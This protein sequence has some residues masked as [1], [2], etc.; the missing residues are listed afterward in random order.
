MDTKTAGPVG[1]T[2]TAKPDRNP[3]PTP[4]TIVHEATENGRGRG[5]DR[6][7]QDLPVVQG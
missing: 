5:C 4:E 7:P 3:C 6:A 2:R 1:P